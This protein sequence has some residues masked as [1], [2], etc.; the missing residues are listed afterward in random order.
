MRANYSQTSFDFSIHDGLANIPTTLNSHARN[1]NPQLR[2]RE[3]IVDAIRLADRG[4]ISNSY[5]ANL[6]NNGNIRKPFR[7]RGQL[8][9]T[10]STISGMYPDSI[11]KAEAYRL[12]LAVLFDGQISELRTKIDHD[13]GNSARSDPNGFYH[14]IPI[15]YQ[16]QQYVLA[17]PPVTFLPNL[18]TT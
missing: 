12:V 7:Y 17:G 4:D 13:N 15:T 14:G 3:L 5:S 10:T 1:I 6:I 18:P 16:S 2:S 11:R 9:T 8:Y